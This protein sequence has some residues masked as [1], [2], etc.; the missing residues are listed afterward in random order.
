[1]DKDHCEIPG[2]GK[3][4]DFTFGYEQQLQEQQQGGKQTKTTTRTLK[5]INH[6]AI[7]T[8]SL[9]LEIESC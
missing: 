2:L 1:M 4:V 6:H 7:K 5:Q 8:R 9:S 3:E